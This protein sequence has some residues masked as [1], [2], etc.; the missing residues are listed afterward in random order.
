MITKVF[1]TVKINRTKIEMQETVRYE[2]KRV[3]KEGKKGYCA[4]CNTYYNYGDNKRDPTKCP[5]CVCKD[6]G[7]SIMYRKRIVYGYTHSTVD[8]CY[9]CWSLWYKG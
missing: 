7:T 1:E 8:R 3:T 2:K 4:R 6:C 9:S 5:R